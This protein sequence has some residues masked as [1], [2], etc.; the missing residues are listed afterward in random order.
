[1]F[2]FREINEIKTYEKNLNSDYDPDKRIVPQT[3]ITQQ[4]C[5]DFWKEEFRKA[6]YDPD[7]RL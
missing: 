6:A 7:K 3:N 2:K 4:E 5:D 1:M